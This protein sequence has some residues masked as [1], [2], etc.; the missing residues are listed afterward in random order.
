MLMNARTAG[1]VRRDVRMAA[2]D[3]AFGAITLFAGVKLLKSGFIKTY[4]L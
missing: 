3:I 4:N 1:A 2:E